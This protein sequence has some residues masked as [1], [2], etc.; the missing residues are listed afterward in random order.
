MSPLEV[1][2]L[3]LGRFGA[4]H[5]RR[6]WIAHS[7]WALASGVAVL[8]LAHE[9]YGFVPWVVAFLGLTW[10]S[11]LLFSRPATE[12]AP[13]WS[14][15]GR[16]FVSYLTRV[17]YQETLFFLLP[18]YAY[19]VTFPAWNALFVGILGLLAVFACL[20][21]VFDDLLRRSRAFALAFFGLVAF[22]ALNLLLPMVLGL[23]LWI[24]TPL[25]AGLAVATSAPLAY[26]VSELRRPA[27]MAQVVL[28]ILAATFLAGAGRKWIPPVPLRLQSLAFARGV[29]PGTLEPSTPLGPSASAEELGSGGLVVVA[30]V[31]APSRLPARVVIRWRRDGEQLRSSR[32]VA[33]TA[34]EVG[35][36]IWDVL[37]PESG[38]GPGLYEVEVL[39]GGG[40]LFGRGRLRVRGGR[41]GPS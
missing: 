30:R 33:V 18:F 36:R 21:L 15:L 6:F 41:E 2:V 22:A 12:R 11:T 13:G 14:R 24:V 26:P 5:R 23:G 37:A 3:R 7:V 20:D 35:F 16:G 25:A 9:R 27:R 17:M 38:L 34:H 10:A 32:E 29:E 39:T 4:R 1:L 28:A 8:I 40:Q 31:F 19:S